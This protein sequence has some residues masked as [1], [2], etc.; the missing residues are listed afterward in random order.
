MRLT[1]PLM[2][3]LNLEGGRVETWWEG[4]RLMVGFRAECGRLRGVHE[5]LQTRHLT[6]EAESP[7]TRT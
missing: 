6:D 4:K 1:H 5:S 3:L 2:H 7:T